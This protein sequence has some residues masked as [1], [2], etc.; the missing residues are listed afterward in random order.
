[1]TLSPDT[2]EPA[3]YQADPTHFGLERSA[4]GGAESCKAARF[5]LKR[6]TGGGAESCK[7][8]LVRLETANRS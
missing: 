8:I 4:E 5:G 1:M 7:A 2:A 6:S 3:G